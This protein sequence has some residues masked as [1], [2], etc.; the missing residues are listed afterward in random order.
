MGKGKGGVFQ[1][2]SEKQVIF[3]FFLFVLFFCF[4]FVAI[5]GTRPLGLSIC[6]FVSCLLRSMNLFFFFWPPLDPLTPPSARQRKWLQT[7]YTWKKE[8]ANLPL[9]KKKNQ[10]S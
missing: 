9:F 1:A 8:K 7:V 10:P 6:P 2:S 4:V 5:Y 3:Y